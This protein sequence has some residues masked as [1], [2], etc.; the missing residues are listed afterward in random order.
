MPKTSAEKVR[1]HRERR[2]AAGM[3]EIRI[4]APDVRDPAFLGRLREGMRIINAR[5]AAGHPEERWAEEL[6][7][8]GLE[9]LAALEPGWSL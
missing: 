2:R 3:R 8:Q 1:V 6:G 5:S 9:D 7:E 4:W